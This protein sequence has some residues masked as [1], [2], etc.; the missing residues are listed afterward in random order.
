MENKFIVFDI[1]A[2]YAHFKKPYTTT[3]PLTFSIPPISSLMGL[4]SAI[5]GID[6]NKY[7]SEFSRE[8]SKFGIKITKPVKKVRMGLNLISTNKTFFEIENRK[9]TKIEYLKDPAYRIYFNHTNKDL[10]DRLIYNLRYHLT[11]YTVSLGLSE[12]IANFNFVGEYSVGLVSNNDFQEVTSV[13]NTNELKKTDVD[14]SKDGEYFTETIPFWMTE[15]NEPKFARKVTEY[16][17]VI[18][19]R[20]GKSIWAKPNNLLYISELNE[21]FCIL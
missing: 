12:N 3:S 8:N 16:S 4:I 2:D 21:K 7:T 6:K 11:E 10:C 15:E 9:P 18:F 14:F 17:E 20:N 13:I 1:W 19:E 5:I